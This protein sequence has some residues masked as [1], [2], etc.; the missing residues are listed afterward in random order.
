MSTTTFYSKENF[1]IGAA[2]RLINISGAHKYHLEMVDDGI[3]ETRY[4]KENSKYVHITFRVNEN[5]SK[6][7]VKLFE[8]FRTFFR[9]MR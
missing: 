2:L 4:R 5:Y 9:D 6:K 1:N 7:S 3:I 8:Q